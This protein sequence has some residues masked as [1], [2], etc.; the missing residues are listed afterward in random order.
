MSNYLKYRPAW[1]QIL[2]FIGMAFGIFLVLG[3]AGAMTLSRITGMDILEVSD[4]SKWDFSDSKTLVLIRGLLLVQ[5][6]SLFLVPVFLFAY[7]SDPAPSR[8]LGLRSG[9]APSFYLA[10]I[11][12]LIAAIPLAGWLGVVNEQIAFP[13][14]VYQ[15]MKEM[16]DETNRQ[17]EFLLKQSGPKQ[18]ILNL[19]FIAA[20]AG[21][22]EEL[23]FR[24]ILQR[25]FIRWFKSPW[26][27]I[28]VTAFIF[29]AFHLQ[30][31]GLLPR[32]ALGILLGAIYWY[33]GSLW[34]AILAHF[35]Y[36]GFIVVLA[37]FNPEIITN[38]SAAALKNVPVLLQALLSFVVIV[39]IIWWMKKKS[40]VRFEQVYAAD[41]QPDNPF[42]F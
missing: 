15:W 4:S 26:A 27:G 29:S 32:F 19:I 13:Q 10:G 2:I 7:F 20:L 17:V 6:I 31:I 39:L 24:G 18:L 3:I 35:F 16:E 5:F 22:G 40:T 41:R 23:F 33:S 42:S 12:L 30:F 38:D 9:S 25:L 36:D 37:Y 21:T 14:G 34:P 11:V 8:Y 1:A 28:V